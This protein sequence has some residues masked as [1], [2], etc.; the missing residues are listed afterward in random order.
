MP[1][2]EVWKPSEYISVTNVGCE[3]Q[4]FTTEA[5]RV[6]NFQARERGCVIPRRQE[7]VVYAKRRCLSGNIVRTPRKPLPPS[8]GVVLA[9][10]S[11]HQASKDNR[12][13]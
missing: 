4:V 8:A 5:D 11:L 3:A 13:S 7:L 12:L 6:C 1:Q 9:P 10:A 2:D